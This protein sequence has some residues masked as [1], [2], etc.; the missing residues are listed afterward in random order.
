MGC[1]AYS[2]LVVELSITNTDSVFVKWSFSRIIKWTQSK[3]LITSCREAAIFG[4]IQVM[5]SGF[6]KASSWRKKKKKGDESCE[7]EAKL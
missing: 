7:S 4:V 3:W 5:Y 2:P 1:G 6:I